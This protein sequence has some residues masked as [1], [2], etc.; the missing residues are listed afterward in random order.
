MEPENKLLKDDITNKQKFIETLL[1]HNLK[2]LDISS[3][4]SAAN[5]ARKQPNEKQHYEKNDT[6]LNNR[7]N[8]KK[9]NQVRQVMKK[10]SVTKKKTDDLKK[11][12]GDN[13]VKH[14]KGWKLKKS[15]GQNHNVYVFPGQ[16]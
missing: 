5:E 8:K 9:I 10:M 2:F 12:L 3:I 4:I 11:I 16:R 13:M 6:G 15:I 14:V 7:Q 1:Q